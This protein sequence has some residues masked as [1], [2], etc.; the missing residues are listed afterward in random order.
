FRSI[1]ACCGSCVSAGWFRLLHFSLFVKRIQCRCHL[2]P[3]PVQLFL[4]RPPRVAYRD[5]SY[6]NAHH[7]RQPELR[8][9]QKPYEPVRQLWQA[10]QV[11]LRPR[12]RGPVNIR[13]RDLRE[14]YLRPRNL[15][16]INIR[17]Q[18]VQKLDDRSQQRG[19]ELAKERQNKKGENRPTTLPEPAEQRIEPAPNGRGLHLRGTLR[20]WSARRRV[21]KDEGILGFHLDLDEVPVESCGIQLQH[22]RGRGYP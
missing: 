13:P 10:G 6:D 1:Q 16:P 5:D 4:L 9:V 7:D 2:L 12:D 17:N 18:P 14:P 19:A 15:R 11:D 22:C 21:E 8:V 20:S 3:L